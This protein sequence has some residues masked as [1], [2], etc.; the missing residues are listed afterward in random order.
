MFLVSTHEIPIRA[1][2][3]D[4]NVRGGS[5]DKV[6]AVGVNRVVCTLGEVHIGRL[7]LCAVC[8]VGNGRIRNV[9]GGG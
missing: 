2:G 1:M 9:G 6:V 8:C 4:G 5:I 3:C 7:K